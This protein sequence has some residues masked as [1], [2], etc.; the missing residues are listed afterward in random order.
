MV[1]RVRFDSKKGALQ[2]EMI[3]T[4]AARIAYTLVENKKGSE[5]SRKENDNISSDLDDRH[6]LL[7]ETDTANIIFDVFSNTQNTSINIKLMFIQADSILKEFVEPKFEL[8]KNESR[9]LAFD[10]SI[11][12]HSDSSR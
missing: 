11:A 3:M 7:A 4:G 2:V 9:Q 5:I 12:D 8:K 1:G 6:T 10:I